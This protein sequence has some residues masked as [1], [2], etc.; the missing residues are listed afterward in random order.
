LDGVD[1]DDVWPYASSFQSLVTEGMGKG[2]AAIL[3][4]LVTAE[5]YSL[6]TAN[7]ALAVGAAVVAGVELLGCELISCHA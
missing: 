3:S 4:T 5:L 1:D 6:F 7:Q 2:T